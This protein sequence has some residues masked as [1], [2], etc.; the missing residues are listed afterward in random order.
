MKNRWFW[1]VVAVALALRLL[2][3]GAAT[4]ETAFTPDSEGY[5]R[6]SANMLERGEFALDGRAEIFRTP[7]YPTFLLIGHLAAADVRL[8]PS[9]SPWK[10]P[11][12]VQVLLDVLLVGLVYALGL[13]LVSGRVGLVAATLQAIS[14][15]VVASSCRVLSDSLYSLLFTAAVLMMVGYLL[16]RRRWALIASAAV[17]AAACYVRPAALVMAAVFTLAVLCRPKRLIGAAV[18]LG[19]FAAGVA[20]WV[21]RNAIR[22][23]Y[24]GFSSLTAEAMYFF[25]AAEVIAHNERTDAETVRRRLRREDAERV[26]ALDLTPGEAARSRRRRGA[27]VL[28]DSPG[29]YAVIHAK[30]CLAFWLPGAT[31]VLEVAGVTAGGRNTLAVLRRDG[32]WAAARHYFGGSAGAIALAVPMVLILAFKYAAVLACA[33]VRFRPRMGVEAWLLT[34]IV[35]VSALLPGVA[36]VPR[37]RVPVEPILNVAAAMGLLA[38]WGW[39]RRAKAS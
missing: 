16:A 38:L 20:P 39:A 21:V 4:Q 37:F 27:K 15:V 2:L 3:L 6:L 31:D 9:F 23:D 1:L 32:L 35:L 33:V 10:V 36:A 5:W 14:P 17:L 34:A 29:T 13:V 12:A 30:G 19:V 8:D 11:V 7:G 28:L 26:A 18:C 24:A 25:S 22:A